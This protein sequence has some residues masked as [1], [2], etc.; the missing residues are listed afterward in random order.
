MVI[1]LI[2]VRLSTFDWKALILVDYLVSLTES[3]LAGKASKIYYIRVRIKA[4]LLRQDSD[5]CGRRSKRAAIEEQS[6]V[7]FSIAALLPQ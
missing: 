4:L 5:W 7:L 2:G 1:P 6:C 3:I